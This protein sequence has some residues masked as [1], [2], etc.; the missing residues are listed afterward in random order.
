MWREATIDL[1]D[2]PVTPIHGI[3]A[4]VPVQPPL[5]PGQ[6]KTGDT[7]PARVNITFPHKTSTP[8]PRPIRTRTRQSAVV[9]VDGKPRALPIHETESAE[10]ATFI[11]FPRLAEAKQ[12]EAL[13]RYAISL[14]RNEPVV[15]EG[16]RDKQ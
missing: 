12:A 8:Q 9:W 11:D 16:K 3:Y 10:A 14:A 13:L 1:R 15:I 5:R 4:K 2:I 7:T 6:T